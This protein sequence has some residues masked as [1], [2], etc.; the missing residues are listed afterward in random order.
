[1]SSDVWTALFN[2]SNPAQQQQQNGDANNETGTSSVPTTIS[3]ARSNRNQPIYFANRLTNPVFS[4]DKELLTNTIA[5]QFGY[6]IDSPQLQKLVQ[7]Q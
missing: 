5:N 3:R 6:D 7:N 2:Q 1:M 4:V